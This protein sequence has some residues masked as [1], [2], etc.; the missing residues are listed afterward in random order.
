VG[1]AQGE[2]LVQYDFTREQYAALIRLTATLCQVLPKI[3][4]DYPRDAR[5][6]LI[7]RKLDDD[8]LR[9]YQGVL[10]HYHIQANKVDPGP[11]FQF[12]R[13]VSGAKRV[14]E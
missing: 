11:A 8:A 1:E 2:E 13:V 10:G 5:G 3:K 6:E 9:D 12:D 4:C 14:M 7:T